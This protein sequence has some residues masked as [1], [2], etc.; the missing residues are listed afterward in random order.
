MD[1]ESVQV[2]DFIERLVETLVSGQL[3]DVKVNRL[4]THPDC[5]SC[6][7]SPVLYSRVVNVFSVIYD[8]IS[9]FSNRLVLL[10][11]INFPTFNLT[12]LII[13]KKYRKQ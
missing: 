5:E 11:T 7:N 3:D 1:P 13:N 4:Y 6:H 8:C 2:R 12:Q 9:H 10:K